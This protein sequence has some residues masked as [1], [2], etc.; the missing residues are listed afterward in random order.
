MQLMTMKQLN[1]AIDSVAKKQQANNDAI[2]EVLV[3]ASMHGFVH[4]DVSAF[5]RLF[6]AT[7]GADRKAI[8]TWSKNHAPVTIAKDGAVSLNKTKYKEST[9]ITLDEIAA[10]TPWYDYVP[11]VAEVARSLDV[12][13]RAESLVNQADK[14]EGEIKNGD[15]VQFLKDAVSKFKAMNPSMEAAPL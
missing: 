15:F 3:H 12:L 5:A 9:G 7:K 11:S 13:A 10:Q 4:S 1:T 14:A 6:N 8:I 2:Q